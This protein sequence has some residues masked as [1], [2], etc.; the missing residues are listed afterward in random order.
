MDIDYSIFFKGNIKRVDKKLLT[1]IPVGGIINLIEEL[2]R[3]VYEK[4][5]SIYKQYLSILYIS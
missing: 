1:I 5:S 4:C 2:G 3:N